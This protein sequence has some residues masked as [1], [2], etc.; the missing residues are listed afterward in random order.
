MSKMNLFIDLKNYE[1]SN[2]TTNLVNFTKNAQWIGFETNEEIVQELTIPAGSTKLLFSAGI[3]DTLDNTVTQPLVLPVPNKETI[4]LSSSQDL[5]FINLSRKVI[6]N[7]LILSIGRILAFEGQDFDIEV[8]QNSSRITWKNDLVQG[9]ALSLDLGDIIN[10]FYN[11]TD[12]DSVSPEFL[13]SEL[14]FPFHGENSNDF[15]K[16][17]YIEADKQCDIAINGIIQTTIRPFVING[18]ARNGFFMKSANINDVHVINRND[19]PISIYF[20]T[21]K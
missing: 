13:N 1:S 15:Y 4:T 17:I 6:P 18:T 19:E 14:F 8:F 10:V 16:F 9:E 5:E 12:S 20:L 11:Y 7:T 2:S 21:G 3:F